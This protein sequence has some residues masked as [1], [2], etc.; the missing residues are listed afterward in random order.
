MAREPLE[1]RSARSLFGAVF[2]RIRLDL[3]WPA[4]GLA[5]FFSAAPFASGVWPLARFV[6]EEV[7][8]LV[9]P[10]RI[11]VDGGYHFYNPHRFPILQGLTYPIAVDPLHPLTESP[12]A[13]RTVGRSQQAVR[14]FRF[15][16]NHLGE[17]LLAPREE[18]V[19]SIQYQQACLDHQAKYTL[20]TTRTW[21]RPLDR[22]RFRL[23]LRGVRLTDSNWPLKRDS[24]GT[25]GLDLTPFFPQED[26]VIRWS[27]P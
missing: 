23:I 9:E 2:R 4:V 8:I 1:S 10:D 27:C 19:F 7:D 6:S 22:A 11:L 20:V 18:T 17:L 21:R 3:F 16:S 15:G 5:L 12:A 26:W 24:A 25:W 14:M 13:L